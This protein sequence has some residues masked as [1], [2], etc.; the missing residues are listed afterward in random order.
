MIPS[1]MA[2]K[3]W[4]LRLK[5]SRFHKNP[6]RDDHKPKPA[7]QPKN[8][9]GKPAN[10]TQPTNNPEKLPTTRHESVKTL[11]THDHDSKHPVPN[12]STTAVEPKILWD[13]AYDSLKEDEK[14][15]VDAYEKVLSSELAATTVTS[16]VSEP[17]RNLIA[18]GDPELRRAQM[19]QLVDKGLAKTE[20]EANVKQGIGQAVDVI[21]AANELISSSIKNSPE[22][23]LAWTGVTFALQ[24]SSSN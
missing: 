21:S 10:N 15:L 11:S 19:R 6:K 9:A 1:T 23:S 14:S 3:S 12:K 7:E 18:Q 22:A 5:P 8:D 20:R 24:V 2:V 16:Q 4:F 13:R 17:N